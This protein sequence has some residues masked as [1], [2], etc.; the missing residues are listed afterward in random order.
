MLDVAFLGRGVQKM[1]K[2]EGIL[3]SKDFFKRKT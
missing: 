2:A 1:Y 3:N